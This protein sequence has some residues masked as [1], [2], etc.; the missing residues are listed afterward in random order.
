MSARSRR[1]AR[2]TRH[3]MRS[4]RS[5]LLR[6]SPTSTSGTCST[7][8]TGRNAATIATSW[9]ARARLAHSRCRMRLS[10]ASCTDVRWRIL[11]RVPVWWSTHTLPLATGTTAGC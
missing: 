10:S 8:S 9:P 6:G 5:S 11:G 4:I 2:N 7:G 1:A 3:A